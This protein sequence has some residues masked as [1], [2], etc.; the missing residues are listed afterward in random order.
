MISFFRRAL[1]SWIVLG[2]LVLIMIAFIITGVGAPSLTGSTDG[3]TVA[4]VDGRKIGSAELQQR[5]RNQFDS[6]RRQQPTLDQQ[7]FL[8]GGGFEGVTEA[9]I[10]ARALE[11]WG[12]EQGFA[13][14]KRLIDAQIAGVPAFRG[15]TGQFD[16]GAMRSV[17]A[18][19]RVSEKDLRA[20]M[21]SDLIRGQILTPIAAGS[22]SPAGLARP[23]AALLLEQ[24]SGSVGIIPFGAVLD[25]RLPSE[26][27]IAAAYKTNIAAY[28]R[29]EARQLRYALFGRQQVAALAT[30]SDAEIATYFRENATS[31]AARD[32]RN[33]SQV[34]TPNETLARSIA[35]AAKGGTALAAVAA[36]AGLEAS[37]L[38][39]QT[40]DVYAGAASAAIAAQAFTVPKAGIVGP[41]KGAFG[42]YVV[43]VDAIVGTPARTLDQAKPEIVAT[44]TRQKTETALSDL[45][46]KIED[47]IADGASF[48]EIA[49]N[50]KLAIVETPAVLAGGQPIDR[51]EWKAPAELAPL[52]KTGFEA[53]AE[54]RPTIETIAKDEEYALLSVAKVI[55]PTPVPLAQVRPAVVR[56]IITKRA[57]AR[58][59][60]LGD[61]IIA[62]V[63]KGVPLA[64]AMADSGVKLPPV[65]P[66]RARQIDLARAAQQGTEIPP[67]VRALFTLQKGKAKLSTGDRGALFITVL[68]EVV[69]GNVAAAADVINA[70]RRELAGALPTELGDQFMRAV[71]QDVD[72]KRYPQAIAAARRQFSGGQQ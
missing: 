24:R 8:A 42:W 44:L 5:V 60:A 32:T 2:L 9:L 58:A 7:A 62:A 40:R 49:A 45:A 65:Q 11:A 27:E 43:K 36:K 37:A 3:A 20:D 1:S 29:P 34:I 54:D 59:K 70:T 15:V 17:L 68:E 31:Y 48:A 63:N 61:R 51:P 71:Q 21:A 30:P 16:E 55:P 33:L 50:N 57:A 66:A 23:Y 13:I 14:S 28:T 69:P 22:S 67:P 39:G 56:D 4:K 10:G 25:P 6:L 72:T 41:M 12:R 35:A 52:L 53:G 46:G 38:T 64:K 26:A 47:A 18:Q 19:A